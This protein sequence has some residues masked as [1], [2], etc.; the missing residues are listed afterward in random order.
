MDDCSTDGSLQ[1][2]KELSASDSRIKILGNESNSGAAV[3]RNRAIDAATGTYLAFLDVDD[4]WDPRKLELYYD[5]LKSG[6]IRFGY[7]DYVKMDH[8]GK[9]GSE[10]IQAP[11]TIT[12]QDILKTCAVCTSTA[13]VERKVVGDLRMDPK[14]RRGQDYVFWIGLLQKIERAE[15]I[16]DLPLTLYRVGNSTSLSNNKFRKAKGQWQIYRNHLHLNIF[17]A[18]WYMAH[19]AYFGTLKYKR[20]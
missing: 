18:S 10:I 6:T 20:F 2:L 3:S 8:T 7:G 9:P 12:Y 19:Y 1:L 14:L 4:L 13:V 16:G 17:Q 11:K 15:K 5:R